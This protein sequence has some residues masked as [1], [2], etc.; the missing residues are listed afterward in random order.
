[1]ADLD[2]LD[3]SV[4]LPLKSRK[5]K[6]QCSAREK[7][8]LFRHLSGGK[9]PSISCNHVSGYCKA[10][11]KTQDILLKHHTE[12]Y[13]IASQDAIISSMLNIIN[14]KRVRV[15]YNNRKKLRTMSIKYFLCCEGIKVR[16]CQA[17]FCSVLSIKPDR[18]LRIARH[19][20]EHGTTRPENREGDRKKVAFSQKNKAIINHI[21]SFTCRAS[22]YGRKGAPG[23]KYWPSDLNVKRMHELFLDKNNTYTVGY[24][25][26]YGVFMND[27]NLAFGYPATDTCSTCQTYKLAIK[28]KNIT[29]DQKKLKTAL[30]ILHRTKARKFYSLLNDIYPNEI[31]ICFDM[32]ENLVLP[33]LSIGE[34]YY[35]R[36]AYFYVLGVVIHKGD[37]SQPVNDIYFFT[38]MECENRKDSNMI[39]SAI[40]HL[41]KKCFKR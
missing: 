15:K 28:N 27:F 8:K 19:W 1:M 14:V 24:H 3:E 30:F 20:N 12:F 40:E 10:R 9:I 13:S 38:W 41:L 36:Q 33:K 5:R 22:H 39:C 21:Q 6:K 7:K 34:A 32:M 4:V 16:V 31:T 23:R 29:D 37:K 25:Y 18:V 35:S 17:S 2:G 26:Y 11:D